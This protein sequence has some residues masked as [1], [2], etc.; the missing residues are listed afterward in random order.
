MCYR[1]I[2]LW[3][4]VFWVFNVCY[5]SMSTY[6]SIFEEISGSFQWRG[7]IFLSFVFQSMYSHRFFKL[8]SFFHFS[9]Y[10][11]LNIIFTQPCLLFLVFFLQLDLGD[12][13]HLINWDFSFQHFWILFK[14]SVSL[15]NFSFMLLIFHDCYFFKILFSFMHM[16]ICGY[17]SMCM[18]AHICADPHRGPKRITG[19]M[20]LELQAAVILLIQELELNLDPLQEQ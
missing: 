11:S 16:C 4:W 15:M 10:W 14:I 7:F 17:V 2:L 1:E 12:N 5:V 20:E 9:S 19:L 8:V 3:S 13:F 18:Y 6:F